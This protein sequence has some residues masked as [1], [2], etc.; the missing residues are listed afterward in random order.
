[1]W[2]ML[3]F[4][5]LDVY[6]CAIEFARPCSLHFGTPSKG[7]LEPY[8]AVASGCALSAAQCRR[9][10]GMDDGRRRGTALPI[11]RGSAMECAAII[12]SLHVLSTIDDAKRESAL[13]LVARIVA[14]LT[15]LCR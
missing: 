8:R 15:K 9:S 3:S 6:R 14:M 11:A 13:Q 10:G 12:D 2:G 7:F 1:M 4:Q 5:K